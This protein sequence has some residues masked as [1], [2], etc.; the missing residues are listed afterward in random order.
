MQPEKNKNKQINHRAV[1]VL[2]NGVCFVCLATVSASCAW[3]RCLFRVLG[4]GVCFACLATVSVSLLSVCMGQGM[5]WHMS[6]RTSEAKTTLFVSVSAALLRSSPWLW[7]NV[8]AEWHVSCNTPCL[9]SS[10]AS[11]AS[12]CLLFA[13]PVADTARFSSTLPALSVAL[14]CTCLPRYNVDMVCGC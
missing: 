9:E 3:Q 14:V 10:R 4:N 8:P 12:R 2:G 11:C 13:S 7:G 5:H 1:R 6:W